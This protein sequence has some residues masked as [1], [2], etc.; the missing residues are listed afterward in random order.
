VG[1]IKDDTIKTRA[2]KCLKELSDVLDE[3]DRHLEEKHHSL[4]QFQN[5]LFDTLTNEKLNY[6]E[7][8]SSL[9]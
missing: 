7:K 9:D 2:E 8:E 1:E 3:I 4:D 6:A 5:E